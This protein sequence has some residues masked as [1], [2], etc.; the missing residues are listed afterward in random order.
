MR[1]DQVNI[2]LN[3]SPPLPPERAGFSVYG[4]I[5]LT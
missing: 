4:S 1:Y 3:S 2:D 5:Y